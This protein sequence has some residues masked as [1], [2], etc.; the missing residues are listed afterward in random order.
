MFDGAAPKVVGATEGGRKK[1]SD[2][3]VLPRHYP[4]PPV[5]HVRNNRRA[6]LKL[7]TFDDTP[8]SNALF[9]FVPV[10]VANAPLQPAVPMCF[11]SVMIDLLRPFPINSTVLMIRAAKKNTSRI[12]IIS[13]SVGDLEFGCINVSYVGRVPKPYVHRIDRCRFVNVPHLQKVN[14]F[15]VFLP[16]LVLFNLTLCFFA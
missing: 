13:F 4:I 1:T 10:R 3:L 8:Q 16:V 2:V 9:G 15:D 14:C 7:G 5:L 11:H 12:S 6:L